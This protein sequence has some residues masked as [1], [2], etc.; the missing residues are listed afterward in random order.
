MIHHQLKLRFVLDTPYY[1]ITTIVLHYAETL[2]RKTE[3][4]FQT[5][6]VVAQARP[7]CWLEEELLHFL[8]F[9][10]S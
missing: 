6:V 2:K 9:G 3:N 4:C 8:K 7:I 5:G 10:F 1:S